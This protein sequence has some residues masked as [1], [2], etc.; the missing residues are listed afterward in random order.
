MSNSARIHGSI[1][2]I[3][4]DKIYTTNYAFNDVCV[5]RG[6]GIKGSNR[7]RLFSI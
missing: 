1:L 3:N 6:D 4:Y 7:I 2:N 5:F